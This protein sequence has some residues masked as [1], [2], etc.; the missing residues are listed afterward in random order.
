MR[1]RDKQQK[2]LVESCDV[3]GHLVQLDDTWRDAIARMDYPPTVRQILGEAFAAAA[4][5]AST[6]KFVTLCFLITL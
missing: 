1:K 2:F 6:I 4:L 5:L 3:R